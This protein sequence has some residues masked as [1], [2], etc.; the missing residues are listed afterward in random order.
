MDKDLIVRIII[1]VI[2]FINLLSTQFN[3]NP[4]PISDETVYTVV[5]AV[6]TLIT[7]IW[8]FWK[9]NNFTKEA[10]EAQLYLNDLK[11]ESK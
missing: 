6:I 7:W 3:F 11:S 5:S 4:L 2:T 9:N 10:K 1:S 8:G